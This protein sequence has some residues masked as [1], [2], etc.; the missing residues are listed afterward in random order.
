VAGAKIKLQVTDGLIPLMSHSEIIQQVGTY[1]SDMEEFDFWVPIM[2]I[3][4]ILGLTLD[5]LPRPVNYLN[6]DARLV[7]EWQ[8]KLGSKTRMRIGF[9]WS[10]RRDSWLNQHKSVPF[11]V[12]LDLVK[13]NPQ[14]EWFNLQIDASDEET[15]QMAEAGVR[16]F[17]NSITGFHD[18]AALI[19]HMDVVISVDT[20]ISHLSGALGRPTWV[21]L[22]KFA[23]DWRWLTDRNDSPWYTTA[24]LFRQSEFNNWQDVATRVSQFLSWFKV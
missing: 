23:T 2:S 14:F 24:R 13:R 22:Q 15:Q 10:G 11:S 4:G 16:L 19:M 12:M 18:T 7:R 3:P 20:A 5:N 9:S 6:A 21:M 17:P 8:D 1:E